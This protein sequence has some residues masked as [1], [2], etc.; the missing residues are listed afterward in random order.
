[1]RGVSRGVISHTGP[2]LEGNPIDAP[3]SPRISIVTPSYNQ[4]QF[5]EDTIRSVLLQGYPNLEYI[6]MDGGSNDGTID[7]IRKYQDRLAYWDSTPDEGQYDAI[8]K[9]FSHSTGDIMAWLNSDDKYAP[10]ALSVVADVFASFPDVEWITTLYG[11][12]FNEQGQAVGIANWRGFNRN[13]FLRGANL[14][15]ESR[16]ATGWIQQ[17]SSFWRRSLWERAGGRVDASLQLAADFDLWTRFYQHAQLYGIA[18]LLGGFRKHR[19][20]KTRNHLDEYTN[21]ARQSLAP[22]RRKYYGR[23]EAL[24]RRHIGSRVR[25]LLR[26][27]KLMVQIGLLYDAKIIKY[28]TEERRWQMQTRYLV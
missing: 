28:S 12:T 5:I 6:V 19:W 27:R 23:L 4:G 20:Q 13:L 9:G 10:S 11:L 22:Y 18:A 25:P 2:G 16:Y 8:N 26:P 3:D 21:E 15:H 1:M 7:V 14:P 17:E 24:L